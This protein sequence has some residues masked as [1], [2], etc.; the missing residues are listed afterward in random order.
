LQNPAKALD[1]FA[2]AQKGGFWVGANN[3]V[4]FVLQI[5]KMELL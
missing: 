3:F 1:F 2:T 4:N 5:Q